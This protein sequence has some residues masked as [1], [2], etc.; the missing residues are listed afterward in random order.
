MKVMSI[1]RKEIIRFRT[2]SKRQENYTNIYISPLK[3]YIIRLN[4]H[5]TLHLF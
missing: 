5:N 3:M 1:E 4:A 2:K